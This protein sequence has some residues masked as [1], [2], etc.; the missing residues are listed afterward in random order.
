MAKFSDLVEAANA[1]YGDL[2][3]AETV[4]KSAKEEAR[5]TQAA[6]I[7]ALRANDGRPIAL[8]EPEG[9]VRVYSL[10]ADATAF[11]FRYIDGY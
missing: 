8:V 2:L 10:S 5:L 6:V 9:K 7:A 4:L 3:H 1:A 11:Q